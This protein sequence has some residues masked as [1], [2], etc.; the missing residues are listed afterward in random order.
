MA[1]KDNRVFFAWEKRTG[2]LGRFFDWFN[3]TFDTTRDRYA[4]AVGRIER[5]LGKS[6]T[7]TSETGVSDAGM[8]FL[9]QTRATI[10]STASVA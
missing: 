5:S 8:A 2:V 6:D 7:V 10:R 9:L 1:K 4:T 3:R